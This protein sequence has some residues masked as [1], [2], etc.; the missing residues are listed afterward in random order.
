MVRWSEHGWFAVLV[1]LAMLTAWQVLVATTRCDAR[2]LLKAMHCYGHLIPAEFFGL[3]S[4]GCD[5]LLA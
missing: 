4:S 1:G 2:A 3:D 5:L